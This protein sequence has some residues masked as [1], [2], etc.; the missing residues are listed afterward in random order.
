MAEVYKPLCDYADEAETATQ[1]YYTDLFDEFA[2]RLNFSYTVG[3]PRE[4]MYEGQLENGSYI[5][6]CEMHMEISS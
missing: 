1:G 4:R 3:P 5:G 2:K 6:Q